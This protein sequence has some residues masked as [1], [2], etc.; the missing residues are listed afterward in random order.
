MSVSTP[1]RLSA[2]AISRTLFS[3]ARARSRAIRARRRSGRRTRASAA[4]PARAADASGAQGSAPA[5]PSGARRDTPRALGVG[6]V[7]LHADR[8]R[9][10][11]AQHQPRVHRA[12]GCAPS[13][14]CTNRSH[15]MWSS[16][17]ATTTPPTLSLWP[18]RNFVVLW[19]TRSA[20]NSIGRCTYGL[21]NVLSTT[22]THAA[23]VRGRTRRREVGD[24][25]HRVGGR[26]DEQ[27]LRVR[28]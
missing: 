13:A 27:Q 11:A 6:V 1:P 4:S 8:Q 21:A 20:P 16:R 23:R 9:L 19:S 2:S 7:P 28:A 24:A 3:S 14:F 25:Q 15:S 26:L 5:S 22:T 17:T 18:F 10:G 12:R